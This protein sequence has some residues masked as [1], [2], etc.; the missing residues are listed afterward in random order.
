ME[1]IVRPDP[2]CS[3]TS[4]LTRPAQHH[5]LQR[6]H[7]RALPIHRPLQNDHVHHPHIPTACL[8]PHPPRSLRPLRREHPCSSGTRHEQ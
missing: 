2:L 7:F 3:Q 8:A 6:R 5:K 1:S 4:R